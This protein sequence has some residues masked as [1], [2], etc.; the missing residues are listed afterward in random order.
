MGQLLL[1]SV[2]SFSG[3][4]VVATEILGTKTGRFAVGIFQ[5]GVVANR[6]QTDEEG[7]FSFTG[8]SPGVGG[9]FAF[10]DTA[11]LLFGV[12]LTSNSDSNI[13]SM[14]RSSTLSLPL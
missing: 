3:R 14:S 13:A 10:N 2:G 12:R 5:N 4:L 11:F 1:D 6:T 9:L 8:L 7:H